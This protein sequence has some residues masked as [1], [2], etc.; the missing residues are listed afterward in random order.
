MLWNGK[1]TVALRDDKQI[2]TV[3]HPFSPHKGK[4][5][6]IVDETPGWGE[7]RLLCNDNEGNS[8][9]FLKSWTDYPTEEP[10]NPFEGTVDFWYD[11]LQMLARLIT[12]IKKL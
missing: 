9:I 7:D 5:Y 8:R 6:F 3:T 2:I 12:D 1:R 11:D 10:E 4:E